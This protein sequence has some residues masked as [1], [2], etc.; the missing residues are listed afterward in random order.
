[1]LAVYEMSELSILPVQPDLTANQIAVIAREM[2]MNIRDPKFILDAVGITQEQFD[3][4]IRPQ[5]YYK[6]AYEAFVTEWESAL[7]T[8]KRIA[9]QSAAALEDALP[10]L[11]SRM[12]KD[13]EALP[14]VVETAKLLAKLAGAGEQTRE[15][16]PGERFT[17]TINLGADTLKFEET[18]G[19]SV[20]PLITEKPRPD[21]LLQPERDYQKSSI[22]ENGGSPGEIAPVQF[23]PKS[24]SN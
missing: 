3:T 20:Q 14:A 24:E 2:A 6:R 1:M 17:I 18:I 22:Q 13:A 4:H 21:L 19:H 7:T 15:T 10:K 8:N 16:A 11:A 12:S 5:V 23:W 9:L